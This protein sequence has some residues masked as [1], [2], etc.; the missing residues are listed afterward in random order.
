MNG[1]RV[2]ASSLFIGLV[3]SLV[4]CSYNVFYYVKN[5][6]KSI[7]DKYK[8]LAKIPRHCIKDMPRSSIDKQ[9][10]IRGEDLGPYFDEENGVESSRTPSKF[11]LNKSK[12]DQEKKGSYIK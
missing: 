3:A 8:Q 1:K 7:V 4:Y 6:Q 10:Q 9:T 11:S 12:W 2:I 5:N